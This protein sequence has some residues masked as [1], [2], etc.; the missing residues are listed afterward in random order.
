MLCEIERDWVTHNLMLCELKPRPINGY[1]LTY[2]KLYLNRLN[3]LNVFVLHKLNTN[4]YKEVLHKGN[5]VNL[6]NENSM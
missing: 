1:G 3:R 4:Q 6:L 2:K 5:F